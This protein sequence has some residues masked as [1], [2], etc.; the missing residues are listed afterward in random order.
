[1]RFLGLCAAD[2]HTARIW[3]S[4]VS[5]ISTQMISISHL[6]FGIF[7][8]NSNS[9]KTLAINCFTCLEISQ[10]FSQKASSQ[11][12]TEKLDCSERFYFLR[13]LTLCIRLHFITTQKDLISLL[14]F[15]LCFYFV[16]KRQIKRTW[17]KLIK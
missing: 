7:F 9:C 16:H 6:K 2:Y 11:P 12:N 17:F 5:Y 3:N 4:N 10:V 13:C 1:M 14:V 15:Y 8:L